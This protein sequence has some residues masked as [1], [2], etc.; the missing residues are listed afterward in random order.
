MS[1]RTRRS[2]IGEDSSGLEEDL[3]R[4]MD[5]SAV[6]APAAGR[7][8]RDIFSADEIFQRITAT[9]D[10]EFQRPT[11]LLFLSGIAAG[12]SIGLSFVAR[13]A[14][15]AAT[16]MDPSGLI[17]NL[18]YPLGFLLIVAGRYQLFTENTLTPV[19]LV[20]TRIASVPLLLRVWGV[21]LAANVLGAAAM[22]WVLAHTG[23]FEPEAAA[24]ARAFGEHALSVPAADLFWKGVFAGWIVAS[25]VWLT[26]AARDATARILI[27]FVLMFLI[28]SADLFHCIIGACEVLFLWFQ[29]LATLG[30]S[31]RFFGAVVAGNTVGGVLLVGILNFAQTR[32]ARFPDR[33][34]GQLQLTWK[35]WLFG[36]ASGRPG[37]PP[38][39]GSPLST[40]EPELDPAP[41]ERDHGLGPVDADV[42]LVQYGD[43]ECPTSRKIFLQARR[44]ARR[45][46]G[47]VRYVFRHFPL[48]QEHPHAHRAAC[49]AEAAGAQDAFWEMHD[50]LFGHQDR[51]DDD[52]LVNYAEALG[53]D[54]ERFRRDLDDDACER[55]VRDDRES[56]MRSGVRRS[57][58][59]FING[60][61]YWGE[62]DPD[63]IASAAWRVRRRPSPR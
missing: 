2:E 52:D 19:T 49:A 15:T 23:V 10:E 34:C 51:L 38:P 3:Q 6:G 1:G 24:A 32:D 11:R 7:A 5:R 53:L 28:P 21:V 12:L 54:T 61:R 60:Q 47:E 63:R 45:I 36:H 55:R 14:L 50:E 31:A 29:G 43:Y 59:L 41:S 13:A 18:L 62:M 16:P 8:V 42:T 26:H 37:A 33:D 44:A 30:D 17:G 46:D 56:G 58:N 35:E 27:V 57:T 20:L 39:D 4:V 25:M 40:G 48:S 22:A 9:A